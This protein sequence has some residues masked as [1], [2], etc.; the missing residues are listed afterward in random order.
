MAKLYVDFMSERLGVPGA[1]AV[2]AAAVQ[3]TAAFVGPI[4][5]AYN[6]EGSSHFNAPAQWGGPAQAE[7]VRGGCPSSSAWAPNGQLD[8]SGDLPGGWT[9][10][11]TNEYVNLASEPLIGGDFHLPNISVDAA[12]QTL[13]IKTYSQNA[14][15]LLDPLDTGFDYTSSAQIQ[16]KQYSRQCT[17]IHGLGDVNASFSL[18]NSSFCAKTNA[19]AYQWALNAAGA[20][21]LARFQKYGQPFV[22]APDVTFG[23]GPF[24]IAAPLQFNNVTDASGTPVISVA[25]PVSATPID[26]WVKVFGKIPRPSFIPDPG[27]FHYAKLLSPARAAE[28]IYVDSLRLRR[29]LNA[30]K[31]ML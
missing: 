30:V 22:F 28:W 12:N 9:V 4:I 17:F 8:I 7:C 24:W 1:G 25:C 11:V 20:T 19:A 14:W 18:D 2:V 15:S 23:P 10:Q 31:P 6:L 3:D 16:T 29:T 13:V 27:C 5:S 21:T 26:E